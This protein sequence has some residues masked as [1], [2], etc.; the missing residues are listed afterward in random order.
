LGEGDPR[1]GEGDPRLGEG[2][3]RLGDPRLPVHHRL[4]FEPEGDPRLPEG[5][6]RLGEGDPRLGEGDPRL[7]EGD[8]RLG[9]G[10]GGVSRTPPAYYILLYN[11]PKRAEQGARQ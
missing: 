4:S 6:P 11:I 3:P 8:P 7:G 5:D 2:D 9:V 10:C 1:L